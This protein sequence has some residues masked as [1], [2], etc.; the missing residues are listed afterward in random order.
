M[1]RRRICAKGIQGDL[2]GSARSWDPGGSEGFRT[3]VGSRRIRRVPHGSRVAATVDPPGWVRMHEA[4]SQSWF[5]CPLH[6][7][8]WTSGSCPTAPGMSRQMTCFAARSEMVRGTEPPREVPFSLAPE[9]SRIPCLIPNGGAAGAEA[10]SRNRTCFCGRTRLFPPTHLSPP[11]ASR[12]PAPRPPF[13]RP[14]P[15]RRNIRGDPLGRVDW[16]AYHSRTPGCWCHG[17]ALLT[18]SPDWSNAA[19]LM[20]LKMSTSQGTTP[21]VPARPIT[22]AP[23]P[24]SPVPAQVSLPVPDCPAG[25][26]AVGGRES[27][28]GRRITCC[29]TAHC[30]FVAPLHSQI[31]SLLPLLTS[32][33]GKLQTRERGWDR[34]TPRD[35]RPLGP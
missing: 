7:H 2:E 3:L 24:V 35:A 22:P 6:S 4:H 17:R 28:A 14:P 23:S 10:G 11:P 12:P 19:S 21:C 5:V 25:S 34:A 33:P 27:A 16:L 32:L 30:W 13:S 18:R 1:R 9:G 29:C 31:H 15:S 20:P 8:I 26:V